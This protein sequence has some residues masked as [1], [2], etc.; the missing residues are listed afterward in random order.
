MLLQIAGHLAV[1]A[2]ELEGDPIMR[3]GLEQAMTTL[4]KQAGQA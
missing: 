4:L 1:A 2:A 3:E